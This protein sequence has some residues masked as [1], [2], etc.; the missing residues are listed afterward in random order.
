MT[1]RQ[2]I[3]E[4]QLALKTI[5]DVNDPRLVQWQGDSRQG[6]Q[7][8]VA[9]WFNQQEKHREKVAAFN[10]RFAIERSL[11]QDGFSFVAGVDEVGRGPLAGP[12]VSAAVILPP[13]FD[14]F[15]VIDSKQLPE[16][17]RDE[18]YQLIQAKAVAIG[19]GIIEA[20]EIDAINIYEA[21]RK[22][23]GKAIEDLQH[24][25]DY[26]LADAM[27]LHTDTPQQSL[28]KGDARS[29]TIGAAS[30]IAK[31]TRDRLMAEYD[32]IYPGYG[33]AQNAGYGTK[34]HLDGL[35]QNGLTPIHRR[36]FKP[37]TDY[38]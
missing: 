6:V 4:I 25:V 34:Q 23:M 17:K 7:K 1:D 3:R 15:D 28:I 18:L 38:Q 33:F 26:I 21:A 8:A 31:V 27:T 32:R 2:T 35:A 24:P 20:D 29:N 9:S 13:D 16:K 37:V 10:E 36:S 11:W 14:V 30:I 19:I 22:A 12:V 5:T